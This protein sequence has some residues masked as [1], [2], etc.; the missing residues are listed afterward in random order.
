MRD[1]TTIVTPNVSICQEQCMDNNC[2]TPACWNCVIGEHSVSM[3]DFYEIV[4]NFLAKFF[5][6]SAPGIPANCDLST[7]IPPPKCISL[8]YIINQIDGKS[9]SDYSI[10]LLPNINVAQLVP[11]DYPIINQS[12][13]VSPFAKEDN[14]PYQLSLSLFAGLYNY[15]PN[16]Y[17][18]FYIAQASEEAN[19]PLVAFNL[20]DAPYNPVGPNNIVYFCNLSG[21]NP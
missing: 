7:T 4:H 19:T 21:M 18:N 10:L 2:N 12:I 20:S 3:C 14:S 15:F 17:C 16:F 5:P 6:N 1:K 9:C 13:L 8:A 11:E